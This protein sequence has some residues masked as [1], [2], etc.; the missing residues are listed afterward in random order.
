MFLSK[1]LHVIIRLRD[2]ITIDHSMSCSI[3]PTVT[4]SIGHQVTC[5]ME[6]GEFDQVSC[7]MEFG[8]LVGHQV[9]CLM[10]FGGLV[11][12]KYPGSKNIVVKLF[13]KLY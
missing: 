2:Q 4:W 12:T 3:T 6:I 8:G 7:P 5:I 11:A 9:S 1:E 13:L 10:E